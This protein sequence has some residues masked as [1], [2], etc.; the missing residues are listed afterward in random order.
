MRPG[1]HPEFFRFP[2]PEGRSRESTI[3]LDANG[4]FT[5][6]GAVVEHA[7]LARAMHS[8]IRRHPE[9][10]RFILSNGYDWTYLTVDDA[11]FTVR[12]L[13]PD[14][15]RLMLALD[16]ETEEAWVP[17][18]TRVGEG[19]ALYTRVKRGL[20]GAGGAPFE[21]KFTRHAQTGLEPYLA[22]VDGRPVVRVGGA[23][24]R[25]A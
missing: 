13:R 11:P 4:V 8:W 10:G 20:E 23:L 19:G 1:D 14:G 25:L 5:H 15:D 2:A 6:D 7:G 17:E 18:E 16:D 3:R 24:R 21:A 22:E 12:G 9:D